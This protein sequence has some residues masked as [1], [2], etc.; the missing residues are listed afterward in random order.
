[1]KKPEITI[2]DRGDRQI[3]NIEMPNGNSVRISVFNGGE[4]ME[5]NVVEGYPWV[6]PKTSNE[7]AIKIEQ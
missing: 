5:L 4:Y 3:V 6:R 7:L 1:M 2:K